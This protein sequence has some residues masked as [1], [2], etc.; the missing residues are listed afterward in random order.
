MDSSPYDGITPETPHFLSF[1]PGYGIIKDTIFD[2]KWFLG[3]TTN[4][5]TVKEAIK[6]LQEGELPELIEREVDIPLSSP[7]IV[8]IVGPRRSGKTYLLFALIKKLLAQSTSKEQVIY[9]NFDD[10][11]FLPCDANSM[12]LIL[13]AYDS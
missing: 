12:E 6:E 1:S 8:S 4:K 7:K 3:G 10:P 9:L 13:Q 5:K 2:Q 11:Q